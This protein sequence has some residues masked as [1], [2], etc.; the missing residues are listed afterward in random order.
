[1]RGKEETD[2]TG[3]DRTEFRELA[4]PI[5]EAI[6]GLESEAWEKLKA[7]PYP[8]L[9]ARGI[10]IGDDAVATFMDG[11][12]GDTGF[13][14]LTGPTSPDVPP[15]KEYRCFRICRK[16]LHSIYCELICFPA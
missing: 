6:I 15:P 13:A 7:D 10:D 12:A 9:R 16:I 1:M 8:F 3:A 2:G 11:P 5:L 14:R 4:E